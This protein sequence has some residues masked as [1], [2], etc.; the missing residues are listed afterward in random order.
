MPG[1]RALALR[2]APVRVLMA[3]LLYRAAVGSV[4]II[5]EALLHSDSYNC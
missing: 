3:A 1:H 4:D 2:E 5:A